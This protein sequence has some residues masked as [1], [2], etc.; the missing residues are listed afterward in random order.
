MEQ[1]LAFLP[2]G[3][4]TKSTLPA[5]RERLLSEDHAARTANGF[6]STGNAL[7]V[8]RLRAAIRQQRNPRGMV[9]K[10]GRRKAER[11]YLL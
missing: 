5:W 1:L 7:P 10:N 11:L 6:L 2:E 8:R 4:V 9:R 3:R